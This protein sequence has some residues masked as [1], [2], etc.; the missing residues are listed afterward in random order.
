MA[1]ET[2]IRKYRANLEIIADHCGQGMAFT[3]I[4]VVEAGYSGSNHYQQK[5]DNRKNPVFHMS[6][7][8]IK[9]S[10]KAVSN[11][12]IFTIEIFATKRRR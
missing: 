6:C 9:V 3:I 8:S 1:F 10:K 11:C 4:P 5:Q 7:K 12:M 2:F